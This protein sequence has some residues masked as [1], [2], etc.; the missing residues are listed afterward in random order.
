MHV[1]GN[2]LT[3][4]VDVYSAGV[5]RDLFARAD[6]CVVQVVFCNMM[7]N[8]RVTSL[9]DAMA[10]CE[11]DTLGH[12]CRETWS[13]FF[14]FPPDGAKVSVTRCERLSC[15]IAN[16]RSLEHAKQYTLQSCDA[17]TR[18]KRREMQS[19]LCSQEVSFF[20]ARYCSSFKTRPRGLT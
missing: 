3:S 11:W 5:G 2:R 4:A 15:Q 9:N 7:F 20:F 14:V 10:V 1:E 18:E 17:Q 16:A 13:R 6:L 8:W 19:L 12:L